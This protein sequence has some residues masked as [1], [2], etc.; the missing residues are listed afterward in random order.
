MVVQM[1]NNINLN[2]NEISGKKGKE[3][4]LPSEP[5]EEAG[6]LEEEGFEVTKVVEPEVVRKSGFTVKK[7]SEMDVVLWRI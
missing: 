3:R 7:P 2:D 6:K 5:K 1:V 4:N